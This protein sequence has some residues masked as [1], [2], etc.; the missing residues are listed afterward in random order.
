M[1]GSLLLWYEKRER[2]F[3]LLPQPHGF[4]GGQEK[5]ANATATATINSTPVAPN[6]KSRLPTSSVSMPL[7]SFRSESQ[8][9]AGTWGRKGRR[10]FSCDIGPPSIA[11]LSA[12]PL[13]PR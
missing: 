8:R 6:L 9:T 10:A 4:E 1:H 5:I 12:G 7:P 13:I 2:S 11:A 3:R